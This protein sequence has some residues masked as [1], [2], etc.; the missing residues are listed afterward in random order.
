MSF[1]PDEERAFIPVE[2][3]NIYFAQGLGAPNFFT[4]RLTPD[5]FM[6]RGTVTAVK[7]LH[8][9]VVKYIS[10]SNADEEHFCD[11]FVIDR[12]SFAGAGRYIAVRSADCVPILLCDAGAGVAGAVHAG[13][14][15]TVGAS[16]GAGVRSCGG[17]GGLH[18]GGDD[19]DKSAEQERRGK[20]GELAAVRPIAVSSDGCTDIK[21]IPG[22][23]AEA[24]RVMCARGADAE[25]IRAAVGACIH[26]CCFEVRGD[27]LDAVR[28]ALGGL[29]DR[30][31]LRRNG[32]C[33]YDLPGLNKYL[34]MLAGLKEKNIIISQHCTCHEEEFYSFR[35]DGRIEGLMH[36]GIALG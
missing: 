28:A 14:R 6:P 24:V 2:K 9:T 35:R 27:F 33:Y 22:I 18:D 12:S 5:G 11:G 29:S 8:S 30:F 34:L 13:W 21:G 16:A 15:G 7:Q 20:D 31:T 26:S 23:A 1:N 32:R 17:F 19:I 10:D 3:D 25:N 36:A 4:T